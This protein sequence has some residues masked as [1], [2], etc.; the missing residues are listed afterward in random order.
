[1]AVKCTV[2]SP[3][4]F[5]PSTS[6]RSESPTI[7]TSP[8][9]YG[10]A[11]RT[12]W[13]ASARGFRMP[14]SVETT[15]GPKSYS[16]P[17]RCTTRRMISPSVAFERS[18]IRIPRSRSAASVSSTP[19]ILRSR[20]SSGPKKWVRAS[21]ASSS[22][23]PGNRGRGTFREGRRPPG[24]R[25]RSR[26]RAPVR[27]ADREPPLDEGQSLPTRDEPDPL[28]VARHPLGT[29]NG[30]NVGVVGPLRLERGID[31]DQRIAIVEDDGAQSGL[32]MRS[33]YSGRLW[34]RRSESSVPCAG[35]APL[36]PARARGPYGAS[37]GAIGGPPRLPSPRNPRP[38]CG[39]RP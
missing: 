5:P 7:E 35:D 6:W 27:L 21:R 36:G 30:H 23:A 31:L 38:R 4:R 2:R 10:H 13:N 14:T 8:G 12:A 22:P 24:S 33:E 32:H 17:H 3:S 15:S 25:R 34:G 16:Q 1:M 39:S 9:S 11:A 18:A 28:E 29:R 37:P 26:P 20:S 19:R